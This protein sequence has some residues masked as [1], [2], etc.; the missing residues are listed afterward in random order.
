MLFEELSN[1][2]PGTLSDM[3]MISSVEKGLILRALQKTGGNQVQAAHLLGINR[4]TL[5]GKMDRYQIK[6]DVLVSEKES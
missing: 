2:P 6:K 3:D 1:L 4:S 5:R